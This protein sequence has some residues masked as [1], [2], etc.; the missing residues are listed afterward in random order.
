MLVQQPHEQFVTE[1]PVYYEEQPQF[2]EV[3]PTQFIEQ[4][5]QYVETPVVVKSAPPQYVTQPVKIV[6]SG[7]P[8]IQQYNYI[9]EDNF[10]DDIEPTE[11][12]I[13]ADL[14]EGTVTAGRNYKEPAPVITGD[15]LAMKDNQKPKVVKSGFQQ[16]KQ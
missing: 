4:P 6:K 11:T 8:P 12:D 10:Y 13:G 3:Q 1:Q 5:V 15:K 2:V 16:K 7:P 9:A 14:D